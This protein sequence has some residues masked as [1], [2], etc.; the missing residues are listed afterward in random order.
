MEWNIIDRLSISFLRGPEW[1]DT[2]TN[3]MPE[4]GE[5]LMATSNVRPSFLVTVDTEGDNLWGR[6]STIKTENA[7]HLYRF[8]DLCVSKNVRPTYLTNYE[9]AKSSCFVSLGKE[10]LCDDAGEIGMHLHAWDSPPLVALTKD[11]LKFHPY[12]IEY[13][14]KI[15]RSK[16]GYMTNLLEDTFSTKMRSHRSGRWAFNE[17]Y[18]A[19][20]AD[21]GYVVDCSVTPD[22]NWHNCLG[23]P[24]GAGGSDYTG[25]PFEA[26]F[27][28]LSDIKKKGQSSL[29]ELPLT[30]MHVSSSKLLRSFLRMF[31]RT[32]LSFHDTVFPLRTNLKNLDLLLW[33]VKKAEEERRSYIQFMLHSSE[34]MAGGSP[35]FQ[36]D[37]DIE[38]LY[39][40]LTSLFDFTKDCGFIG[41]TLNEFY[42]LQS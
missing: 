19:A 32:R 15:M 31:K 13:P 42:Q 41:M 4:T 18:A 14:E 7:Q 16:I 10:I 26:Y 3:M 28:D 25:Y 11:D 23:A 8:Q 20:L 33:M 5:D 24:W 21:H 17:K 35:Y 2:L 30:T 38:R 39:E 1:P 9:M 12:L 36:T 22:I 29:M 27:V 37:D 6:P 34:L 40:D